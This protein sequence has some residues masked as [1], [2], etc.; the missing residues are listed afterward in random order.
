M[1]S[2]STTR[3]AAHPSQ[4]ENSKPF[5]EQS[6]LIFWSIMLF[7]ILFLFLVPYSEVS[8]ALFN[9]NSQQFIGPI[10]GVIIWSS[11]ILLILTAYLL[12]HWRLRNWRD[13]LSIAVWIIPLTY[14]IALLPAASRELSVNMLLIN[15]MLAIF[16]LIG[17]YMAQGE[18]GSTIVRLSIVISGYAI[19]IFGFLNLFGN[20]F[21]KDAVMYDLVIKG[22]RMTSVFQYAN[23]YTAYLMA[24]LFS[25]L[26]LAVTSRRWYWFA[27]NGFML[28]PIM[29]SF[30]LTQSRG[31]YVLLPIILILIIP[32]LSLAKQLMITVYLG[33]AVLVSFKL[34]DKLAA[35]GEPIAKN[36]TTHSFFDATSMGGW[37]LLVVSSLLITAVML[38]VHRYAL[39]F[40]ERKFSKWNE[41]KT[42]RF[43]LPVA[44]I[45]C[46]V[47]GVALLFGSASVRSILPETIQQ[48]V[49]SINFQQQSVLERGTF[50]KDALSVFKD[51]P[52]FGAGGGA[53]SALYQK[54]QSNPYISRQ[55]HNFFLQ[56]LIEV[57]LVGFVLLIAFLGAI[58]YLYYKSFLSGRS[59]DDETHPSLI[60]YIVAVSLLLHSLIDFEMSYVYLAALVFLCLGAMTAAMP[61]RNFMEF[62]AKRLNFVRWGFSATVGC[63]GIVLLIITSFAF[64]ADKFYKKSLAAIKEKKAYAEIISPLNDALRLKPSQPEFVMLKVNLMN[65]GFTQRKDDKYFNEAVNL[66][67]RLKEAEPYNL[68]VWEELYSQAVQRNQDD[69]TLIVLKQAISLFPWDSST[70]GSPGNSGRAS[71][72]ERAVDLEYRMGEKAAAVAN[73]DMKKQ[74]WNSAIEIY[75][76]MAIKYTELQKLPK[77][78]VQSQTFQ[79]TPAIIGNIGQ[80]Y[81]LQ[82]DYTNAVQLLKPSLKEKLDDL[83]DRKIAR[84]YIASLKKMNQTDPIVSDRLAALGTEEKNALDELLAK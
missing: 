17:C 14:L 42:T 7:V 52:V 33:L 81:Y 15:V 34:T 69:Q 27:V 5:N 55:T 9:G 37:G 80:I 32:F 76:T 4:L 53:W 28:V 50:Y 74:H 73:E 63:I 82:K 75:K 67:E 83:H 48:R 8:P 22:I 70:T 45:I 21:Y 16:F 62:N 30:W 78:Q 41:R 24:I 43:I 54:Y 59:K 44:I 38:L 13:I 72:Y 1:K 49:E 61:L 79:I 40:L 68:D 6:S 47:I 84:V 20:T 56:V 35:I 12:I 23:A 77:E 29:A 3:I 18:W 2:K 64:N 71:F 19:V 39:P 51:Y 66:T 31:G 36:H 57:G 46:S 58:F 60:F 26:F 65:Q 11:I 10:Y 25:A